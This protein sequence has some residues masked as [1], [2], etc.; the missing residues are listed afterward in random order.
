M[1][2]DDLFFHLLLVLSFS[3]RSHAQWKDSSTSS[4]FRFTME[5]KIKTSRLAGL[6][7]NTTPSD[8]TSL[9]DCQLSLQGRSMAIQRTCW[10]VCWSLTSTS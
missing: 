5:Q 10:L 6:S 7:I 3:C 4:L 9:H 8:P 1:T 2:T